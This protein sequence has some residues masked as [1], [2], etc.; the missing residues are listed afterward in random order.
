M[1]KLAFGVNHDAD[2]WATC[3]ARADCA[4]PKPNAWTD[5]AEY[6][7]KRGWSDSTINKVLAYMY[8]N[9]LQGEDVAEYFFEKY[10]DLWTAWVSDEVAMKVK[11]AL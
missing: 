7:K 1:F 3:T 8:D 6:I 11:S 10:E 4:D 5:A 2:L 9:Q